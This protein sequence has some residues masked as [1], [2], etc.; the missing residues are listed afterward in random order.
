MVLSYNPDFHFNSDYL[1]YN[2]S[3]TDFLGFDNGLRDNPIPSAQYIPLPQENL[4]VVE[5]LTNRFT[6]NMAAQRETSFMDYNFSFTAGNQF[7]VGDNKLGYLAS[8]S[9]RN[10]THFI[11]NI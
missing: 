8:L 4:E 7:D 11:Q 3:K 6:K 2:G 10:E 5:I 9:Y 1:S